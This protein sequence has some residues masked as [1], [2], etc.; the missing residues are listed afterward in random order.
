MPASPWWGGFYERLVRSVKLPLKKVL[1]KSKLTYEEMETALI[2]VEGIINSRPLTYISDDDVSPPLTPNHLLAGR[3]LGLKPN[4]VV[5]SDVFPWESMGKRAKYVQRVLQMYWN[6]FKTVYLAELRDHHKYRCS[7]EKTN[8]KNRLVVGDVVIIKEN[9]NTPRSSW[10]TGRV[11][12]LVV[13]TDGHVRGAKLRT[14]STD[15]K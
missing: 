15:G 7:R 3:N 6:R 11:D 8:E 5:Q 1:G 10:R 9:N 12:S 13:G 4:E 14:I 2:E